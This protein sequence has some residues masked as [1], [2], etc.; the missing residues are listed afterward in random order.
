MNSFTKQVAFTYDTW[1]SNQSAKDLQIFDGIVKAH[2]DQ[3]NHFINVDSEPA[4]LSTFSSVYYLTNLNSFFENLIQD[5]FDFY[6]KNKYLN[7]TN[8]IRSNFGLHCD[9]G[10]NVKPRDSVIN[11]FEFKM[12]RKQQIEEDSLLS[13]FNF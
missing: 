4:I 13:E 3:I 12:K 11:M 7:L 1:A 6:V 9:L 5:L 10:L 2:I 8:R